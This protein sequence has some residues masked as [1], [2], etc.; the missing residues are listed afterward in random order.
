MNRICGV[1]CS[2]KRK[3][4]MKYLFCQVMHVQYINAISNIWHARY[5][6][7]L[8]ESLNCF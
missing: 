5:S 8:S 2:V 1:S 7:L 3:Y 4:Y 6:Q